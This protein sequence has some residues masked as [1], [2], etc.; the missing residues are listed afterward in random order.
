VDVVLINK[1]DLL[2]HVKFD[3]DAFSQA[4]KGINK[5]VEIFPVS[6]TAGQGIKQWVSWLLNQMSGK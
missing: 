1:I 5:N 3:M 2:P 6:C 4:V